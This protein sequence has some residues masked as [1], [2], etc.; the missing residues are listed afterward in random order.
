[1]TFDVLR[2]QA[3]LAT[4]RALAKAQAELDDPEKPLTATIRSS[5]PRE[6][7]RTFHYTSL[8]SG[9]DIVRE[10]LGRHKIATVHTMAID[11]TIQAA[12]APAGRMPSGTRRPQIKSRIAWQKMIRWLI[13][14]KPWQSGA[15]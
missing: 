3:G 2:Q 13:S 8:S 11:G 12:A 5:F 15:T 4:S 9:L 10:G 7:D 1:V 6:G 14:T